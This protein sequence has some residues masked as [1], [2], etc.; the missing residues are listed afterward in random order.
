MS[1]KNFFE[2]FNHFL[3][4]QDPNQILGYSND[5]EVFGSAT[6]ADGR[7]YVGNKAPRKFRDMIE[8]LKTNKPSVTV[9]VRHAV[10]EQNNGV[11]VLDMKSGGKTTTS[12]LN[13]LM[14]GQ[15]LK[16]FHEANHKR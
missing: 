6:L 7:V 13:V 11:F 2:V 8:A 5:L 9:K 14:S 15:K 1:A 16:C 4:S 3:A 12:T 10:I